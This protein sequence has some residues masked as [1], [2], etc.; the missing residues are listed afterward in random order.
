MLVQSKDDWGA[1]VALLQSPILPQP[2]HDF[3]AKASIAKSPVD[4]PHTRNLRF[5][6][7][8]SR[9]LLILLLAAVAQ[10]QGATEVQGPNQRERY[11]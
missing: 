1:Q 2:Q 4:K 9:I 7:M 5:Q 10:A 3:T 6:F 11:S 8:I